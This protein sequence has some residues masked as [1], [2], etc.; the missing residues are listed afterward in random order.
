MAYLALGEEF[1]KHNK[2][3]FY[4]ILE[5]LDSYEM[6]ATT[7]RIVTISFESD[8][9]SPDEFCIAMIKNDR[10]T[11]EPYFFG[12]IKADHLNRHLNK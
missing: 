5:S 8:K 3:L 12:I 4:A 9:F 10:K 2:Q 1:H 6:E 11:R 7:K